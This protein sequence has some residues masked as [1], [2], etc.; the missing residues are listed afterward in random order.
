MPFFK[1]ASFE[2][3]D[4]PLLEHIASKKKPIL[5]STGISSEQE[6]GD[7]LEVI[8]SRG[9]NDIVLFH[10]ISSYPAKIVEYN[11]NMLKT[12]KKTFST[13]VGL[14]DHI[15]GM[16]AAISAISLGAVAENILN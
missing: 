15:T 8:K 6:I 5:L 12:L 7:A 13:L 9:V 1:V 4:H 16:Q 3:T 10:C 2:I 14:S 11:V